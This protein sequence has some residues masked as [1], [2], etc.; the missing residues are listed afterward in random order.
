MFHALNRLI[1]IGALERLARGK[2]RVHPSLMWKGELQKREAA[3]KLASPLAL[4]E[5]G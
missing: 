2:Y 1:E 3:V 5:P 4:V